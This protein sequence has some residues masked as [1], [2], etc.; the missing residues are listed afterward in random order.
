VRGRVVVMAL[1]L[2]AAGLGLPG[3]AIG[4]QA[5]PAPPVGLLP[6]PD[7]L[8]P[9]PPGS[10][11]DE[12]PFAVDAYPFAVEGHQLLYRSTDRFG[13]GIAVSGALLVPT[14]V[15]APP[16]GRP[17][18]AVPHGTTGITDG[19]APSLD[20]QSSGNVV[21]DDVE[22][23]LAG[24]AVVVATD[25]PGMGGP[26]VHPYLDGIS[27]ARA[28]LDSIRAARD[29]EGTGPAAISG[30]SQ[31]GH[32]TLYAGAEHATYAPDIDLRG[33][34]PVAAPTLLS[35]AYAAREALGNAAA[36][37][38]IIINGIVAARPDLDR[39]ELL[40]QSG[41]DAFADLEAL[42]ADPDS[43]CSYGEI[44]VER[45]VRADPLTLPAWR[46]ALVENEPGARAIDVPVLMVASEGDPTVPPF[47]TE[48]ICAGLTRLDTDL[49][50]W[51]YDDEGHVGVSVESARD[52]ATWLLGVL[53]GDPPARTVDWIGEEPEVLDACTTPPLPP[54]VDPDPD[55]DL[56]ADPPP[57][58][59]PAT[60]VSTA[61]RFTG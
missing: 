3:G 4:A 41:L 8:P 35:A 55:P 26:G 60:P 15:P 11:L 36:Y 24:G 17:V 29:F 19:C 27:E 43:G 2:V 61:A 7:P 45:D 48:L 37:V 51:M 18:V 39:S 14:G 25:Y 9:G 16:G 53:A 46:D 23:L 10:V 57:P 12:A 31:G 13:A 40:T 38:G 49:R 22:A 59:G 54:G 6:V 33:I 34:A 47:M 30:M 21:Y 1:A 20:V 44:D 52:R 32:A 5:P 50:V 42:D 58:A 56:P 28:V